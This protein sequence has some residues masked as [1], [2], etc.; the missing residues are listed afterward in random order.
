MIDTNKLRAA[1]VSKGLRQEDMAKIVG[2]SSKTFSLKMKKGVFG[3]D[4]MEK[5]IQALNI[6]K[7]T[8]IFFAELVT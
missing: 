7:P 1:W 3:S 4:E 6:S 5:M 8:E 2:I